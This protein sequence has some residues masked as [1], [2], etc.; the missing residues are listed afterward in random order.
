MKDIRSFHQ[1]YDVIVIGAGLA[2]LTCG[3]ALAK[4]GKKVKIIEQHS[5]P[6]GCISY[7][8]RDGF[9]FDVGLH[10]TS[11]CEEGGGI[12][13][14]LMALD[15]LDEIQFHKVDPLY[16]VVLPG[17]SYIVPGSLDEYIKMLSQK[18]SSKE[19]GIVKLFD[20]MKTIYED[21]KRLPT[22]SPTIS[23]YMDK[24]F[25]QLLDEHIGDSKLKTIISAN[26]ALIGSPPSRTSAIAMS[27]FMTSFFSQGGFYPRGGTVSL[28]NGL[29]KGLQRYGGEL[30]L[31]TMVKKILVEDGKAI[32]VETKDG[33]RVK[34]D[35]VV[36]NAD[37]RETFLKLIGER[38][39]KPDFIQ[40]L[41][42]MELNLSC[43]GVYLGVDMDLKAM[44]I[45]THEIMIHSSLDF[46]EE[47][48]AVLKGD[49]G[50]CMLVTIPT[51]TDPSIAPDKKHILI[52]LA[53]APYHL[54]G[55]DWKEEKARVT[56]KLI[57]KVEEVIPNLSK[58]IVVK[59]SATPLT[60]ERITLNSEGSIIG[61]APTPESLNRPQPKSPIEKLYLA[62]HWTVPG[63]GTVCVIPSG[64][65]TANMIM[66]E[67]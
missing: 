7:F 16:K 18:F 12:H 55:K 23:K 35:Y 50:S 22:L 47:F 48:E 40:M 43:F 27:G 46:D 65:M 38:E 26:W 21:A 11:E 33:E 59:E 39:L 2:G 54:E 63:G 51:L 66:E 24:T 61:W 44:G 37:A 5:T 8:K 14:V 42:R 25:Q 15:L 53:Y 4:M 36:S 49:V 62:G 9:T 19:K 60:I 41:N 57:N 29:V 64:W 32:G 13:S 67:G 31:G 20:T 52:F 1:E 17:E 3:T 56:E 10:F 28:V 45:A 6:G 34:A 58:H 30:Q